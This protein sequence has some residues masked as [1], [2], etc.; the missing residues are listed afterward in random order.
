MNL[1]DQEKKLKEG[2]IIIKL[3]KRLENDFE[4]FIN[5]KTKDSPEWS[6][7]AGPYSSEYKGRKTIERLREDSKFIEENNDNT[8]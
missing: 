2:F 5:C 7:F 3:V 4:Y 8:D 6:I 1:A